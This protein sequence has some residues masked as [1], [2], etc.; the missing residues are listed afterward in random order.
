MAGL[1]RDT[2]GN[3]YGTA[4]TGGDLSCGVDGSIG[5]GVIFKL[6]PL[7]NET[8]LHTFTGSPDGAAPTAAL[9]RDGDGN[10]YGT[11]VAGGTECA[12]EGCGTVFKLDANGKLTILHR[13]I[14]T[15]GMFPVE[16]L[17]RDK[18]GNLYGTTND[19]GPYNSGVIFEIRASGKERTLYDFELLGGAFPWASLVLDKSGN[20]YGTA[21]EGGE[22][23]GGGC[24][25]VY[26]LSKSGSEVVLYS[27]TGGSDGYYPDAGVVRDTAGN[28][29][30]STFF[31]GARGDGVVFK[32]APSGKFTLLHT[33]DGA[34][35]NGPHAMLYRDATGNLYGT[36]YNGTGNVFKI[37]KHGTETVLHTFVP[38]TDGSNPFG[39]VIL[40]TD[41]AIYGT[42]RL[43]GPGNGGTVFK[44]TH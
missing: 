14:E 43:N 19:G 27:F 35:G 38:S 4:S 41:G 31:G 39:G 28:L 30:G 16:A 44:I 17:V 12:G 21:T 10:L 8:V 36:T 15:D 6:D 26:K 5:C 22:C 23:G 34:D 40:G 20:L 1:V 32:L 7:G 18:I 9:I 11:T 25:V 33:F 37:D 2:Q 3:L 29:Y 13:F 24:G 42:A